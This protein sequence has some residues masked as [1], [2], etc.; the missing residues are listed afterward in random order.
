M[1]F[2]VAVREV[3]SWLLADKHR[4]S[5]F[6]SLPL[7]AVPD[8]PDALL[9]PKAALLTAIARSRRNSIRADMLPRHSSGRRVGPAYVSRLIEFTSDRERGWRPDV[10]AERSESLARCLSRLDALIALAP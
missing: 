5:A 8:D 3:E 4:F 10:A 9:D 1:C 2:R 6:F 7:A